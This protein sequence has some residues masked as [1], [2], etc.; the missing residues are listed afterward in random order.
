M[1]FSTLVACS[2]AASSLFASTAYADSY[3][4]AISEVF[5]CQGVVGCKETS[6]EAI[7]LANF[8]VLDTDKKQLTG[9]QL[10]RASQTEDVEGVTV[11]DKNVFLYGTQDVE[12]WNATIS[13]ETGALTGGITSGQS[14]IALFGNCTKK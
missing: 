1:R 13:L 5:E 8:L 11:T 10:G 3:I 7:N 14:S 12:T 9:A 4:C 6:T 2:I